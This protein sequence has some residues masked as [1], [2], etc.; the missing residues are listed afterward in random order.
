MNKVI[1]VIDT[2]IVIFYF[3]LRIGSFN[4]IL[5]NK[6][7]FNDEQNKDIKNYL[8]IRSLIS[9]TAC[10]THLTFYTCMYSLYNSCNPESYILCATWINLFS[11]TFAYYIYVYPYTLNND[12]PFNFLNEILG[13]GP[14]LLLFS[15]RS[16]YI[17]NYFNLVN[18]FY[19]IC[20]AYAWFFLI[21]GPWYYIT[22][23]VIYPVFFKKKLKE[24]FP[25]TVKVTILSFFGYI[26]GNLILNT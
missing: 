22:N 10:A 5:K 3:Y 23:D 21:W 17:E 1:Y 13:H 12:Y 14:L 7:L 18:F 15:I 4:W 25:Y 2:I 11:T 26:I 9:Y 19:S 6:E 16:I 20:F 24:I 8:P